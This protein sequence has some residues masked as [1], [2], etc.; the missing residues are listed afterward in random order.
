MGFLVLGN[1]SVPVLDQRLTGAGT[2]SAPGVSATADL[3]EANGVF[4]SPGTAGP[5]R[6]VVDPGAPNIN[7]SNALAAVDALLLGLTPT[8]SV[9]PPATV[10]APQ[11]LSTA[12]S[13]EPPASTQ[14]QKLDAIFGV[15]TAAGPRN[16][17]LNFLA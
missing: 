6:S 16:P 2:A 5:L 4:E 8:H 12:P 17:A 13:P 1:A 11:Q 3:A 14:N 7:S 9:A 15:G 10:I